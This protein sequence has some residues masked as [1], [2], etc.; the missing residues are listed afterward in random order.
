MSNNN[1]TLKMLVFIALAMVATITLTTIT[2]AY[3]QLPPKDHGASGFSAG[4]E[5]QAPGWDPNGASADAPGQIIGP[6]D[7][8][9]TQQ[10]SPGQVGLKAGI[11][12]PD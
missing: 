3:A 2:F 11:I 9:E 8:G 4:E 10:V 6:D 5:P 7:P 1:N 12:G